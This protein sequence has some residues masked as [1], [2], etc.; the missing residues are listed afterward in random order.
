MT[1]I[2]TLINQSEFYF[3]L[4]AI[5]SF[6]TV[7]LP[8]LTNF[9]NLQPSQLHLSPPPKNTGQFLSLP[10]VTDYIISKAQKHPI[11]I[12]PFKPSAK[13]SKLCQNHHWILASNPP[14]LSRLLEDKISFFSLCQKNRLPLLPSSVDLYTPKNLKFYHQKYGDSL[15]VQTHFGWAGQSTFLSNTHVAPKIEPKTTVKYSPLLPGYTLTNNCCLT[16]QGLIQSPPALQ[17]TG[18]KPLTDNQ[19]STV[20]R[21]WPCLAPIPIMEK[22]NKIT[23]DF[24]RLILQPLG[25]R[26][27]F[28]LD[29]LI[30]DNSPYLLECNPRLTASFSFYTGLEIKNNLTPLFY[31]HLL[32]FCRLPYE[33]DLQAEQKRF[34]NQNI[35]GSELVNRKLHH[36][37]QLSSPVVASPQNIILPSKVVHKLTHN[38]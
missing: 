37:L 6:F 21:Q 25:Y 10:Q 9:F 4:P 20:G 19:F 30:S 35:I 12:I 22:V 2:P 34:R 16:H 38:A 1:H 23:D 13:I 31:F 28:G 24:S 14:H 32:E 18:L 33:I 26:G 11:V 15:V 17:L 36:R 27:F 5:D 29:F 7:S 3:F 8:S